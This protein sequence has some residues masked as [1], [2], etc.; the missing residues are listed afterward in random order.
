VACQGAEERE[1]GG[2]SHSSGRALARVGAGRGDLLTMR[3]ATVQRILAD[4]VLKPHRLRYCLTRTDPQFEEK[5]AEIIDLYLPPPRPSRVLG[6]DEKTGSQALE[7]LHPM[8]PLRPGLVEC[9]EFEYIRHGTVNLFAAFEVGPGKVFAQCYQRHT[10]LE[11]RPFL[12]A[13][14]ARD[15]DSRWHLSVAT[16][17]SHK[18]QAVLDWCAAQRPKVTLHGLPAHGSW[19]KQGEIGFSSLSRKCLRRA[20]VRS[21]QNLRNLIHRFIQTWNPHFAHPFEWT[22]TGKPL[23][24]APQHYELLAA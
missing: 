18:K 10:N 2:F 15:P 6:L 4:L 3:P 22:Y 1:L 14:R 8:L 13:L 11:F 5:R 17:S 21:P 24:V 23:A 7:R 19:L 20:S 9:Q 16:A 12:H